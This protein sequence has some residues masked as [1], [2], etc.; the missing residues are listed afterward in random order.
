MLLVQVYPFSIISLIL[1]ITQKLPQEVRPT[2]VY[3]CK[4]ELLL[5]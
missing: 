1:Y 3:T 5:G 4:E 2:A